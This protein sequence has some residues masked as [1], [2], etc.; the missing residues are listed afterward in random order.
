MNQLIVQLPERDDGT[1]L[2]EDVFQVFFGDT[3]RDIS[4]WKPRRIEHE[5]NLYLT[6]RANIITKNRSHGVTISNSVGST[7]V[8]SGNSS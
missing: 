1:G 4:N 2:A 3:V 5:I 6:G 8:E 7:G